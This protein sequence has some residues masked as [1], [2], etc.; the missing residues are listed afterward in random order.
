MIHV[1]YHNKDLDG[2]VSG[3]LVAKH[4][5]DHRSS[6]NMIGWNHGDPIPEFPEGEKIAMTDISFPAED[7]LR[8]KPNIDL[9]IDHHRSAI[10]DSIKHQYHDINGVRK[11]GDSAALLTWKWFHKE[12]DP[13]FLVTIVDRYD[14]FKQ[15]NFFH[16]SINLNWSDVLKFQYGLRYLISDPKEEKAK[17]F[18]EGL[19]NWNPFIGFYHNDSIYQIGETIQKVYDDQNKSRAKDIFVQETI[20][21]KIACVYGDRPDIEVLKYIEDQSITAIQF[22]TIKKG[23]LVHSLRKTKDSPVDILAYA[24]LHGGG[25]HPCACGYEFKFSSIT[26]IKN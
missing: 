22:S 3:Y 25:G 8:L 11:E 14:V 4:Y 23:K 7:M 15:D 19:M 18:I 10:E 12:E 2:F 16:H 6:V 17:S 24:K 26:E 13:P 20:Y 21:G 9:W 1:V 5:Y